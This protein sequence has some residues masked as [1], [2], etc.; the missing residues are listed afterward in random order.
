MVLVY[1]LTQIS[2][3]FHG[4]RM[5]TVVVARPKIEAYEYVFTGARAPAAPMLPPTQSQAP[6]PPPA[7]PTPPAPMTP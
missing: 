3:E 4:H 6:Q 5:A 7:Q 2:E 1:R